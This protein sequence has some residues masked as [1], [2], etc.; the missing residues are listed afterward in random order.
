MTQSA[1]ADFLLSKAEIQRLAL[2][3]S[4]KGLTIVPISIYN[5]GPKIKLEVAIVRGKKTHDKKKSQK[6]RDVEREVR[7]EFSDR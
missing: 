3:E 5:K 6:S 1:C 7:R 4:K 2:I